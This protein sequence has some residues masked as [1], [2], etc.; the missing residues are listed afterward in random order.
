MKEIYKISAVFVFLFSSCIADIGSFEIV[1]NSS[2][3][4]DSVSIQPDSK[5]QVVKIP[6]GTKLNFTINM[7]KVKSDGSYLL[8]YKNSKT[9]ALIQYEFG[10]YTNGSQI[11]K[12]I[13]ITISND[14]I[15]TK[16]DFN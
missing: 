13:V 2:V 14:T 8:T 4:L 1:N 16:S 12:N 11:E 10:Y 7:D 5:E 9:T 3:D 6:K 15:I